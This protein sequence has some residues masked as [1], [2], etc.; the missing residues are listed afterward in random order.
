MGKAQG[1]KDG[2]AET[3]WETDGSSC[4]KEGALVYI[5]VVYMLNFNHQIDGSYW[6]KINYSI[7]VSGICE[8]RPNKRRISL[9]KELVAFFIVF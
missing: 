3:V 9:L 8:R 6:D 7:V 2:K 4:G 1:K 5:S